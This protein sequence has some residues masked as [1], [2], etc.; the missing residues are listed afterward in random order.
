MQLTP[1][2]EFVEICRSIVACGRT[3]AEWCEQES[4]DEFQTPLF[5]GG[6]EAIESA[7]CFSYYDASG[8]EW[9]FQVTLEEAQRIAAGER[10]VIELRQAE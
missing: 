8:G 9:W 2:A 7:F 1:D 10:P 6:Y 5:S 4:G 3:E